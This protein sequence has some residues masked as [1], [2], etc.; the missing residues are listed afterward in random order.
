MAKT[1]ERAD[2]AIYRLFGSEVMEPITDD[3]RSINGLYFG[4]KS[5]D[6]IAVLQCG[7]ASFTGAGYRFPDKR[8]ITSDE[9]VLCY[10]NFMMKGHLFAA[11]EN[12]NCRHAW[13]ARIIGQADTVVFID[14]GCGPGTAGLER[15]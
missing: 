14:V 12:F 1:P 3:P 15:F 9:L 2:K 10:C 7:R 5:S 8:I 11:R 4:F 13:L 6:I